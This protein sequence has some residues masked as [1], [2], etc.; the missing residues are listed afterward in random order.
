M[1]VDIERMSTSNEGLSIFSEVRAWCQQK[2]PDV[3][4]SKLKIVLLRIFDTK[5]TEADIY[6]QKTVS[7]KNRR[8]S[9][10]AKNHGHIFAVTHFPKK[11]KL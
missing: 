11:N 7:R 2:P 10:V 6:L 1:H 8:L 9:F 3:T 5:L 4:N